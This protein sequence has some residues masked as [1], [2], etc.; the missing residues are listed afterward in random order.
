MTVIQ[1]PS[2][3][4]LLLCRSTIIEQGTKHVTLVNSFQRLALPR[5]PFAPSFSAYTVLTD[6]LGDMRLSLIVS[7]CDTMEEI[8]TRTLRMAFRNPLPHVPIYWQIRSCSFPLPGRYQFVLTAN[9]DIITQNTVEITQGDS[10][11]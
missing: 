3:V 8:Y 10:R 11:G 6:G 1:R 2:A 4:G 7:R 9:G 5:F